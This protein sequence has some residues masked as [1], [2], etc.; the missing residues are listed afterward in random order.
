MDY[1]GPGGAEERIAALEAKLAER[2]EALRR[3]TAE[4]RKQDRYLGMVLENSQHVIILLDREG[5]IAYCTKNFLERAGIPGLSVIEG[6]AIAD[7]FARYYSPSLARKVGEIIS[8]AELS[9]RPAVSPIAVFRKFE[10][11][12]RY[13]NAYVTI[14]EDGAG[15]S[16][17]VMLLFADISGLKQALETAETANRAKSDFL[18]MM[19]HEIRTPMN[20]IAGM[21]ELI[22]TDNLDEVQRSYFENISAMSQSLLRIINDILD[23]SKIEAGKFEPLPVHYDVWNL[24]ES[25]CFTHRFLA[26]GK[27]LEFSASR[28]PAVPR[29]LYGDELCCRQIL[30]NILN[31]AVKY[32]QRGSVTF[33]LRRGNLVEERPEGPAQENPEGSAGGE[34]AGEGEYLIAE[35]EDTGIGIERENIPRLFNSFEKFDEAQNR[36][37][38]GTGLGLTIVKNLLD[39][40]C[41]FIQVDSEYGRGSRFTVYI[42]LVPG[43][44][45]QAEPVK[46]DHVMAGGELNILLVDDTP[47][48]LTVAQ[49]FLATH[50]MKADTASSGEEALE[51][52]REKA[53][54]GSSYDLILMDYMMPGMNGLETTKRIRELE[55]ERALPHPAPIVALTAAVESLAP[56][57]FAA[58]VNDFLAKPI[59][60]DRLNAILAKWLPP[61][62]LRSLSERPDTGAPLQEGLFQALRRIGGLSVEEGIANTGGSPEGYLLVLRQFCAGLEEGIA[63]ILGDEG[64]AHPA[65]VRLHGYAG[66]MRTL[67]MAA[68]GEWGARLERAAKSGGAWRPESRSFCDALLRFREELLDAGLGPPPAGA[69][70]EGS[71]KEALEALKAACEGRRDSAIEGAAENLRSLGHEGVS[72]ILRLVDSFDYDRALEKIVSLLQRL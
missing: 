38:Q 60:R 56:D 27:G 8:Q 66:V 33:T 70:R 40:L 58:G 48:N 31:N 10:K 72:E 69:A 7:I 1:T 16:D 39:L 64:D 49:G 55:R 5:R 6:L 28:S 21:S 57:F 65:A 24:F 34:N 37:I 26:Q 47:V 4:K 22:R 53:E 25:V 52:V 9:H 29:Y 59:E 51:R 30:T 43:D 68:L 36:A 2:E 62:K 46:T 67:G 20:A 63:G 45:S 13:Y 18:A 14:L 71:L 42:P 15:G 12:P 23:L 11:N 41:G 35:V 17:G 19:S 50:G 61:A 32:T 54:A 44:P 3:V